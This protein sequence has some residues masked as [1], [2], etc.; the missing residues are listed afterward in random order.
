MSC[1]RTSFIFLPPGPRPMTRC[2]CT[3]CRP[4]HS[5][6]R[7][8]IRGTCRASVPCIRHSG[9]RLVSSSFLL[10]FHN[11]PMPPLVWPNTPKSASSLKLSYV[12][13]HSRNRQPRLRNQVRRGGM[14]IYR[15]QRQYFLLTFLLTFLHTFLPTSILRNQTRHSALGSECQRHAVLIRRP[16][17]FWQPIRTA[18][19]LN[20]NTPAP[21]PFHH[22]LLPAAA[23]STPNDAMPR[24]PARIIIP[25]PFTAQTLPIP[26]G[27]LYL[28]QHEQVNQTP[29]EF[30][31]SSIGFSAQ[32]DN[33]LQ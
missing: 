13:F 9:S 6:S 7:K 32:R 11:F 10:L 15:K 24:T 30:A 8:S 19:F 29:P 26:N 22:I 28:I 21:D 23:R 2:R 17:R 18:S 16:L 4:W 31:T 14:G 25:R 3:K 5:R 33:N 20:K 1:W 12:L 27:Q